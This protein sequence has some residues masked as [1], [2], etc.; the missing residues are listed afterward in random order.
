MGSNGPRKLKILIPRVD[1]ETNKPRVFSPYRK[2]EGLSA[3]IERDSTPDCVCLVNK[4]PRWSD[5]VGAY[6]LNFNGRVTMAS[7]KNFQ[8][9]EK[10]S[11]EE[12][13]IL[14]FG[15]IGKNKFS[16][17]YRWPMSAYQAFAICLSAFDG[18]LAC[19]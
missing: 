3:R 8:L 5:S 16:M 15:R 12:T 10:G 6:V 19:E 4:K 17:D 9:V 1:P 2:S 7:V 18:K 13:V 11:D 14:Q